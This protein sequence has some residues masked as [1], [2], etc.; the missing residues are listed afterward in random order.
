MTRSVH[1]SLLGITL[2]LGVLLSLGYQQAPAEAATTASGTATAQGNQDGQH[3]DEVRRLAQ[4]P[5]Q[6]AKTV[7]V[8]F[9]DIAT[10]TKTFI[11]YNNSIE[12]TPEQKRIKAEALSSI[13]A[14]C[15]SEFPLATCCC[16]CNLAK[17]VWGLTKY[18]IA[19]R[20]YGVDQVRE[21][22]VRWVKAV[23]PGGFSGTVCKTGGCGRS[24]SQNGC[25]GMN[26]SNIKSS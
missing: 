4:G 5:K 15:C 8:E 7:D 23:N 12:L 24:F 20:G 19:E 11:G 1:I 9:D 14:P 18:L 2:L 17:S 16:P 26:E 3:A 22:A 13:P 21:A 25:G 6:T 10:Q